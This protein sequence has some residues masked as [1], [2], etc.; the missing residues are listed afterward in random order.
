IN[1]S[2]KNHLYIYI[3]GVVN[4]KV[5]DLLGVYSSNKNIFIFESE[6]N[7]GLAYGLNFLIDKIL[8]CKYDFISRMDS[9]DISLPDRLF[10][11]EKFLDM[12]KSIDV[13]GG[14]C[15]EFG[16]E[17]ALKVK[18]VPLEHND[19]VNYSALRCPFIHPTVMFRSRVF[20]SN[21]RYPVNT[22][23]SEDLALWY[24][25]LANGYKFANIPEILLKY[26]ITEDTLFRRKGFFKA[27]CEAVLRWDYM[28]KMKIIS[29]MKCT[30][31][32]IKMISQ[33]L[34][35]F[36]LKVLYKKYR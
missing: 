6:I 35:I 16:S 3:D 33:I 4:N 23:Y 28:K 8:P 36:I 1:Q 17:F 9:D 2:I 12:N 32:I 15:T 11:Q 34:P 14:Y 18:K 26:R 30:M 27:K 24:I 7:H 29:P 10:L 19:I 25:L 5:K 20:D 22:Y 31:L 13:I 21:I